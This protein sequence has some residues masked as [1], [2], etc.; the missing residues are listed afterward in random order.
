MK[1]TVNGQ[2]RELPD[3]ATVSDLLRALGAAQHGVAVAVDRRI[4]PR[5]AL[6][7]TALHDGATVEI[8][9]AVGGG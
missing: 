9:R 5:S 1:L 7:H 8:V 6:D 2:P 4:V 3:G